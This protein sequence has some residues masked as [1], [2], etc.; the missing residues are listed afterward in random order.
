MKRT[1]LALILVVLLRAVAAA[2]ASPLVENEVSGDSAPPNHPAPYA[3]LAADL[4]TPNLIASAGPADKSLLKLRFVGAGQSASSWVKMTSI[5]IAK[6]KPADTPA[7]ARAI[8]ARFKARLASQKHLKVTTFSQGKSGVSDAFFAFVTSDGIADQ[9][10]AYSP[11][12]GFVSVIQIAYRH[13]YAH[14]ASDRALLAAVMA[15]R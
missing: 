2:Q 9:G 15:G 5:S 7:A 4:G 11:A 3:K 1:V 14:R 8:I 10:I 13:G 12:E 6:V